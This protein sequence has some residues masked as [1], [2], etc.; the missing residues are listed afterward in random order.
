VKKQKVIILEREQNK[1]DLEAIH[2]LEEG[3]N[4]VD[5]FPVYTPDL[6]WFEQMVLAEQQRIRKKLFKDLTIFIIIALCIISAML[7]SLYQI[8]VIFIFLQIT[9]TAFIAL[10]TISGFRKKVENE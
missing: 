7:I 2:K 9:S 1:Q 4:Q 3:L 6:Q 10:Y 5:Q 8:P